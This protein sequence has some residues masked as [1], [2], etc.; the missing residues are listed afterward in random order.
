MMSKWASQITS[1]TIV[2]WTIYSGT[3]K[4]KHQSFASLAFLRG[5]YQWPVNS[6]HK[7]P[8]MQKIHLMISSCRWWIY[9]LVT[10][11]SDTNVTAIFV[12]PHLSAWPVWWKVPWAKIYDFCICGTQGCL[13]SRQWSNVH[14][15]R[16]RWYDISNNILMA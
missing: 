5:I 11:P 12:R 2:Y 4:R 9:A 8:V 1:L 13:Q 7:G 16:H 15:M 6:P 14:E 3:E 10:W